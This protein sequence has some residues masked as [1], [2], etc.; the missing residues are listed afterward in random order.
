MLPSK[1]G[2]RWGVMFKKDN[3]VMLCLVVSIGGRVNTG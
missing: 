1:M 2:V 3:M